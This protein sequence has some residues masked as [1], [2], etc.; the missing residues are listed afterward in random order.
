MEQ[1]QE[2][3]IVDRVLKGDHDAYALLVDTYKGPILN[4]AYRMTGNFQDADDL[5]Q[6]TFVRAFR[7]ISRFDPERR[8]F[9]WL[10][11]ISL[12]LIRNHLRRNRPSIAPFPQDELSW[13]D[14]S[15]PDARSP[16]EDLMAR[17]ERQTLLECLRELPEDL[18]EAVVLRYFQELSLEEV[19]KVSGISLSALKMRVYR[20][21]DKLKVLLEKK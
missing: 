3:E 10:Y 8:F 9:T 5:A 14:F 6:E 17:Q 4:L 12:N 13:H 18:R 11:T 16:E 7:N 20:G 15:D 1:D 19:A 2:R 21:L